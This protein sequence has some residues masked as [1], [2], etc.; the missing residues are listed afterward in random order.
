MVI[1]PFDVEL[2]KQITNGEVDG[3]IVTRYGKNARISKMKASRMTVKTI[4]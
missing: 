4:R 3:K 2:A 1:V